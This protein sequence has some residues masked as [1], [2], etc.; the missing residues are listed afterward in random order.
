MTHCLKSVLLVVPV[1]TLANWMNEFEKWLGSVENSFRIFNLASFAFSA[2]PS[3]VAR[4]QRSGGV[5]LLGDQTFLSLVSGKKYEKLNYKDVLQPDILVIDEAHTMVQSKTTGTA[6]ALADV[7]T[8][9]RILLTGTPFQNNLLEYYHMCEFV[10]P[11][12]FGQSEAEFDRQF[13]APIL[14]GMASDSG[15]RDQAL[16]VVKSFELN[17]LLEPFIHRVGVSVLAEVLPPLTQV[18]LHVRQSRLQSQLYLSFQREQKRDPELKNFFTAFSQLR[19]VSFHPSLLLMGSKCQPKNPTMDCDSDTPTGTGVHLWWEQTMKQAGTKDEG[20]L[21]VE[22]GYKIALLL[23]I[24]AYSET[25]GEKVLVFSQC[26]KSLDYIERVLAFEDW[27]R[28]VPSLSSFSDMTLGGW[29]KARDYLRIDGSTHSSERGELVNTFNQDLEKGNIRAFLISSLAGG[30]G[31]NLVSRLIRGGLFPKC[32][33]L[34]LCLS[35][36]I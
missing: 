23:H 21:A 33:K 18:V 31:I 29:K 27:K 3:E 19:P 12:V 7:K 17:R 25:L 10:R 30:I 20:E 11:G 26:L 35:T 6:K 2:R 14:M 32:T 1:N 28:H 34:T 13:I 5:L 4:W 24:L 8:R 9:R 15:D 22:S 36:Q 16:S